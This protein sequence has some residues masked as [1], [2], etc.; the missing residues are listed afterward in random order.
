[1][2]RQAHNRLRTPLALAFAEVPAAWREI[3][4]PFLAS[5]PGQALADLFQ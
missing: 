4:D 2:T 1:M 3:T 5:A